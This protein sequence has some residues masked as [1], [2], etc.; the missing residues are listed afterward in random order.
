MYILRRVGVAV[1]PGS[2]FALSGHFRVSYA[3]SDA[4]LR[5]A[6]NRIS[7]ACSTLR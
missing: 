1:V 6:M 2:A 4:E 5:E 3:A 7:D